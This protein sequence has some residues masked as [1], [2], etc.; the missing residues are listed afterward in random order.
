[1]SYLLKLLLE[2]YDL[3]FEM[4]SVFPSSFFQLA[5]SPLGFLIKSFTCVCCML[6]PSDLYATREISH[7]AIVTNVFVM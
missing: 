7:K 6:S 4:D 3:R 5:V 2:K 1:M